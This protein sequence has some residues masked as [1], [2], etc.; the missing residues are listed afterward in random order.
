M[1]TTSRALGS[2]GLSVMLSFVGCAHTARHFTAP[3]AGPLLRSAGKLGAA[4]TVSRE[5]ALRLSTGIK[6]VSASHAQ[7]QAEVEVIGPKLLELRASVPVELRPL[8]ET[9]QTQLANLQTGQAATHLALDAVLSDQ[10]KLTGQL[11]EA[12]AAK[13]EVARLSPGY[14]AEVSQLSD[15]AN[16]AEQAWAKDSAEIVKLKTHSWLYR[17]A[18]GIGLLAVGLVLFLQFTGRLALSAGRVASALR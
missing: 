6:A 11:E 12:N 5:T 13:N 4:V 1:T 7:E 14:L 2:L 16:T 9:V 8:V 10:A 15:R 3:D 17:I 18:A